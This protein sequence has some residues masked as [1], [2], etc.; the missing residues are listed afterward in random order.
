MALRW[1]P[2]RRTATATIVAT[3]AACVLGG[4]SISNAHATADTTIELRDGGSGGTLVWSLVL[5][6]EEVFGQTFAPAEM[7]FA[8]GIHLTVTG[9]T[10]VVDTLYRII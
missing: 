6:Q 9:G 1:Q 8:E 4:I 5:G 2:D 3:T 10:A 7:G